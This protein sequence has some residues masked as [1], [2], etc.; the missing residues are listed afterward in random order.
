MKVA[1]LVS[2]MSKDNSI[3]KVYLFNQNYVYG[4]TFR[5]TATRLLG[6][7]APNIEIVGDELI[8]GFTVDSNAGWLSH[9][10]TD[11]N[12]EVLVR[13]CVSDNETAIANSFKHLYNNYMLNF[14]YIYLC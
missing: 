2:H 10:L 12:F 1:G 9:Y 13:I 4:Q 6:K 8:Q 7:N 5:E 11:N 3:K 14:S